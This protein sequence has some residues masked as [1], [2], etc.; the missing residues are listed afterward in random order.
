MAPPPIQLMLTTIASQPALRQRQEYLLR[1]LQVKKIPFVS[2]DLASDEEAK[3]LWRR[4]APLG[5][6]SSLLPAD[7]FL[8]RYTRQATTPRYSCWWEVPWNIL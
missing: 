3:R 1:V 6:L 5:L 7:I 2:Y 4:K 8:Q